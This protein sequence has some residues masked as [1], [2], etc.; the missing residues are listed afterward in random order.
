[1]IEASVASREACNKPTGT[2]EAVVLDVG[3]GNCA[4]LRDGD[5][6]TVVDARSGT[7]LLEE[8]RRMKIRRI[9]H[10]VLS[11]ADEDHI[12]GAL[13]LLPHTDFSIGN[14]WV[15]PDSAKDSEL[16]D[17]LLA[18]IDHLDA[19]GH[20]Q[21]CMSIGTPQGTSLSFGR[22]G[23]TVL[24]P[25]PYEIGHGPGRARRNRPKLTTNGLSVVLRVVID[26]QPVLL[27]PGDIDAAGLQRMLARTAPLTAHTVVY[28]HHG[29]HNG[30]REHTDFTQ[31]IATATAAEMVIFSM[32]R[33]RFKNPIPDVVTEFSRS[34]PQV[35]IACTQLSSHCHQGQLPDLD[36]PHLSERAS[37]GRVTGKCCAG[38]LTFTVSDG[39]VCVDP[40]PKAHRNW[41]RHNVSD[42]M[43]SPIQM[44]PGQRHP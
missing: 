17:D 7:L 24:H 23:L 9:E 42:P 36:R 2:A 40:E 26:G 16:W 21:A 38:T 8:L 22:I 27:L 11:H 10:V 12:Q 14:V 4:I 37:A 19:V 3:H 33:D 25:G 31:A 15:N 28:P 39:M 18:L 5:T 20:V 44:L 41:I 43:C 30:S 34:F 32:G 6:C 29:G 13:Q 35:R 1:M